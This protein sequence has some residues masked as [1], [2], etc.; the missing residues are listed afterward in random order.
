MGNYIKKTIHQMEM[1]SHQ[2][3]HEESLIVHEINDE[4]IQVENFVKNTKYY[5]KKE[6]GYIIDC[7]CPHHTYRNVICKH[8]VIAAEET[9]TRLL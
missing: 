2:R 1:D 7:D 9:N 5:V 8:M 3:A 6:D 4:F